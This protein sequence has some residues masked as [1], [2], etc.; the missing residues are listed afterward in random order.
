MLPLSVLPFLF[1]I[2]SDIDKI[3]TV[4][5][6]EAMVQVNGNGG[7]VQ[8]LERLEHGEDKRRA[9]VDTLGGAR[10]SVFLRKEF[11]K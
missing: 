5:V 3:S 6:I 10:L 7:K 4:G 9:A 1:V 11:G 2:G 8:I